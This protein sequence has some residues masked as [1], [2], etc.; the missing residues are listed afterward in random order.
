MKKFFTNTVNSIR[1][2]VELKKQTVQKCAVTRKLADQSGEFVVNHAVVFA[3]IIG[4]AAIAIVLI[5]NYMEGDL[6]DMVTDKLAD[7]F[8]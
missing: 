3:I 2:T 8:G 1:S 6:V 5:N 7:L 4:A